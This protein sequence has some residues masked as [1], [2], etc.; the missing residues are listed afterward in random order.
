ME[1]QRVIAVASDFL[2]C[3]A[4]S[5]VRS[6]TQELRLE[7]CREERV[8]ARRHFA[9]SLLAR[10]WRQT[11]VVQWLNAVAE[12]ATPRH[13]W[14]PLAQTNLPWCDRGSLSSAFSRGAWARVRLACP[15]CRVGK[16]EEAHFHFGPYTLRSLPFLFVGCRQC[17]GKDVRTWFFQDHASYVSSLRDQRLV[18]YLDSID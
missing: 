11:S 5:R 1:L 4:L 6:T 10:W 18:R 3:R 13:V 9:A 17:V 7:L 14:A 2:D 12:Q 8:V 15:G 16:L